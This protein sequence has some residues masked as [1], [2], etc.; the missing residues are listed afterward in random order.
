[1]NVPTF[2]GLGV[3]QVGRGRVGGAPEV[4]IPGGV[5]GAGVP[6]PRLV[7][8]LQVG[9]GRAR[10][11][12]LAAGV[13][14]GSGGGRAAAVVARGRGLVPGRGHVGHVRLGLGGGGQRG[15]RLPVGG[16]TAG[17]RRRLG[18]AADEAHGAL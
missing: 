4:G 16:A 14:R 17:G 11:M 10:E 8:L 1:M 13:A 15:R 7:H 18:G 9:A 3:G 2:V 12:V 5:D 6:R